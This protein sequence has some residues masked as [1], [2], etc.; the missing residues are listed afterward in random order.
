MGGLWMLRGNGSQSPAADRISPQITRRTLLAS[1][2]AAAGSGLL[3]P[4][5]MKAAAAEEADTSPQAREH[6]NASFP[7]SELTAETRRKLMAVC[8][9]PTIYRRLPQKAV[10]CDPALHVFLIRNPEVVVGI[11]RIM[12]VASMTADRQ[13][14]YLWKGNDGAGTTCDVE[15]VYGTD[16]MHVVYG[17]GFYE[18]SLLKHK[19]TGRAVIVLQSGYG[20][21]A[22][23]RPYVANRLDL[24]VQI[25]NLAADVVARTL[26]PWVGKV[27]DANFVESCIFTSKLSDATEKNA[28]GVQRLA[29]K[30]TGVDP[31]V[32]EEFSRVAAAAGQRAAMREVGGG[33][34][35]R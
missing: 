4:R 3:L 22:D 7:P 21:S 14:P 6:A 33:L 5:S 31:P 10:H 23:R 16:N 13:G 9:R 8:E 1:T 18:G 27:A 26:S 35:R 24:F 34:Q 29:D 25:D 11:W 12:Q 20:H 30:L 2:L 17:D 28:S 15:L 32:R 19:V